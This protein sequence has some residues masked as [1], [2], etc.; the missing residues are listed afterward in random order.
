ME[1][2]KATAIRKR[3]RPRSHINMNLASFLK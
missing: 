2:M 3:G 1:A